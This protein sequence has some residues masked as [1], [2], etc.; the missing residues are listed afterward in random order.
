M[1]RMITIVCAVAT[2]V[3]VCGCNQGNGPDISASKSKVPIATREP[4][5]IIVYAVAGW[6]RDSIRQAWGNPTEIAKERKDFIESINM[7]S[8]NLFKQEEAEQWRF[9][10]KSGM[11]QTLVTFDAKGNAIRAIC[12]WSDF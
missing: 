12:E 6:N 3:A 9:L 4:N 1:R 2:L 8:W 10:D 7:K 11:M 5:C